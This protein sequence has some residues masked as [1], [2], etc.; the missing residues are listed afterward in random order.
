MTITPNVTLPQRTVRTAVFQAGS[1]A[2]KSASHKRTLP[3]TFPN[4]KHKIHS[5]QNNAISNSESFYCS[6][7]LSLPIPQKDDVK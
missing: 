5:D 4:R 6:T 1:T 2:F 7:K 3:P